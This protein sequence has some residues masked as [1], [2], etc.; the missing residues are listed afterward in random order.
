MVTDIQHSKEDA[1]AA[2]AAPKNWQKTDQE[3]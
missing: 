1:A 3:K 2:M